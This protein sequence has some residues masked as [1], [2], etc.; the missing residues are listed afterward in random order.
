[1]KTEKKIFQGLLIT[2]AILGVLFTG[3]LSLMPAFAQPPKPN[4]QALE[5]LN[6]TVKQ[7]LMNPDGDVDGLLLFNGPQVNFPPHMSAD[8]T[9][10]VKPK[11]S[12]SAQ[13]QYENAYVFRAFTIANIGTGKYVS[14]SFPPRGRPPLPP[15]MRAAN[16][17]PLQAD[18]KIVAVL[19]APRG[20]P[21]GAV[22]D[23]GSILR[24]P[25]H[26]GVQ[27]SNLLQIGQ[28]ISAR[29]YGTENEFG[30]CLEVREI[31]AKGQPLTPIYGALLP[32][33]KPQLSAWER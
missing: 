10:A 29:G 14:E 6:G 4:P 9:S 32:Q 15:E 7:Y 3:Y 30:R 12:V 33:V 11:D 20:E 8:L 31:G 2:S 18:G 1:M 5:T 19:F 22:L 24:M 26:L 28:A 16:R 21:S 23:D 17:K 25:P 13:G 27:L